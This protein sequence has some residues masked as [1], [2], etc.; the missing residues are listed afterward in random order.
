[1]D[2]PQPV[3]YRKPVIEDPFNRAG[4]CAT[5]IGEQLTMRAS[6]AGDRVPQ[7]AWKSVRPGG[8]TRHILG[9]QRGERRGVGRAGGH[10]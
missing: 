8:T 1:V 7:A 5:R 4:A 10:W 3:S 6:Y 9:G 2:L